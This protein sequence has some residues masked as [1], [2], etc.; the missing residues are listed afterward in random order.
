MAK[1]LKPSGFIDYNPEKQKIFDEI[2]NIIQN[3]YSKF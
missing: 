2:K 3:N 1:N